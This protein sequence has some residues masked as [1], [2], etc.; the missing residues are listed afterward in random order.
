VTTTSVSKQ[1]GT[2]A[3]DWIFIYVFGGTT[4]FACVGFTAKP[5]ANGFGGVLYRK[6]DG[7]EGTSFSITGL[8]GNRISTMIVTVAGSAATLDPVTVA[9]PSSGGPGTSVIL[10]SITLNN[11]NDWVLMFAANQNGFSGAGFAVTP[12]S[13]FVSQ[14]T[15]GAHASN[16][17]IML[18]DD[19]TNTTGATGT[20]TVTFGG[21]AYYSGVL[22]GITPAASVKNLSG[23]PSLMKMKTA[24]TGAGIS[25][26]SSG[27]RLKKMSVA[28]T[29]AGISV[30]SSG[31]SLKKMSVAATGFRTLVVSGGPRF[32]KM[33][34][35]VT[36][37]GVSVVSGGPQLK[38]PISPGGGSRSPATSVSRRW[39]SPQQEPGFPFFLAVP[40]S[41]RWVSLVLSPLR[42]LCR[43]ISQAAFF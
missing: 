3:G 17:T 21:S 15:D 20:K 1:A 5:D 13:G 24:V 27:P 31:P 6:A 41:R 7:S 43:R 32:K 25:V 33:S 28:V 39:A 19:Q 38:M 29:G 35:S 18:A 9:T 2:I 12:P 23:G 8:A 26:V 40:V 16:A 10:P 14:G 37:A 36:G 30:V 22:V 11:A 42:W 4:S 34:V